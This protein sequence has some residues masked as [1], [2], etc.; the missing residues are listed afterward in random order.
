M[1]VQCNVCCMVVIVAFC[2]QAGCTVVNVEYRLAP[3][4]K[5]PA[6]MNDAYATVRWVLGN[7]SLVGKEAIGL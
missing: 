5:F 3:E 7:R 2:S 6:M 4:H 1:Q